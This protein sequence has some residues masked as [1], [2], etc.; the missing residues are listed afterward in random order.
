MKDLI[1]NAVDDIKQEINNYVIDEENDKKSDPAK[2]IGVKGSPE[3]RAGIK[4]SL[5]NILGIVLGLAF[6]RLFNSGTFGYIF[7]GTAFS[8]LMGLWKS[9]EFDNIALK[10]AVAK[11]AIISGIMIFFIIVFA[12]FIYIYKSTV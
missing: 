3:V 7:F 9:Y 12:V 6:A 11:N 8:F 2:Y 5:S 10:Y 4:M 1:K